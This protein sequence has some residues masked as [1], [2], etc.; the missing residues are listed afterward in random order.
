MPTERQ[1]AVAR[2]AP[3]LRGFISKLACPQGVA[4]PRVA[5]FQMDVLRQVA[6]APAKDCSENV[7]AILLFL[8]LLLVAAFLGGLLLLLLLFLGFS[9]LFRGGCC[10]NQVRA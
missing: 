10:L 6:F 7:L 3:A 2:V 8:I 4:L 5:H 1:R 9:F